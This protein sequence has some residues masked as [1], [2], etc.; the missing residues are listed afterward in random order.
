[1][2]KKKKK[3]NYQHQVSP[4]HSKLNVLRKH[5]S[6]RSSKRG[7]LAKIG[8][9]SPY[10]GDQSPHKD[11]VLF[12]NFRIFYLI[13]VWG[14]FPKIWGSHPHFGRHS[15]FSETRP[16][17]NMFS[18][19]YNGYTWR[20]FFRL[21]FCFFE[22]YGSRQHRRLRQLRAPSLRI[23]GASCSY[24][25][26]RRQTKPVRIFLPRVCCSSTRCCAL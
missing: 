1:M 26:R 11:Q 6:G 21:F 22:L 25:S 2:K 18:L 13:F 23:A 24:Y 9:R 8:Q 4:I 7:V 19:E 5:V 10:F 20:W 15:P 16:S 17:R 12:Q 14:L 3:K